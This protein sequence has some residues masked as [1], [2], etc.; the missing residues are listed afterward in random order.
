M[1]YELSNINPYESHR[2]LLLECLNFTSGLV[3]ELGCGDFS[4]PFI[5]EFCN[6]HKRPFSTFD[7]NE[8]WAT[9]HLATFIPDWETNREWIMPCSLVFIDHAPG[10]HRR[11]AVERYRN[12]ADVMVIHDT[13]EGA[14]YVYGING[15][16]KTFRYIRH[17]EQDGLPRTT[18]IS[19]KIQL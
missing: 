11:I 6:Q 2:P 16:I 17:F 14:D 12:I 15:I 5:R 4:T 1:Q 8:K 9:K 3:I 7:N 13:E 19:D 18:A 10:E